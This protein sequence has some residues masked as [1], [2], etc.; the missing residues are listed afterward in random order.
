MTTGQLQHKVGGFHSNK[1]QG[2]IW[3]P[4]LLFQKVN[5]FISCGSADVAHP[6]QFRDIQLTLF[7]GGV[8][9]LVQLVSSASMRYNFNILNSWRTLQWQQGKAWT[10]MLSNLYEN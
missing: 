2:A 10:K 1:K 8:R 4:V 5:V 3:L 6:R 7:I 9:C